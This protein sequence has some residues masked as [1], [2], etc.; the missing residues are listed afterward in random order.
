MLISLGSGPYLGLVRKHYSRFETMLPKMD[1]GR[2]VMIVLQ[3]H[4]ETTFYHGHVIR[5]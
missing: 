5:F 1:F 2:L 4:A 3:D